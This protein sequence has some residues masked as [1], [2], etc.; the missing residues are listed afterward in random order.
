VLPRSREDD[1]VRV[2]ASDQRRARAVRGVLAATFGLNLAVAAAKV[3]YGTAVGSLAIRADGFHSAADAFNN[4]VLFVG[5]WLAARPPDREHPY[6]HKKVEVFAAMALG[7]GLLWVAFDVLR[8]AYA[9]LQGAPAPQVD[10]IAL[11]IL[12]GTLAVNVFVSRWERRAGQRLMSPA[13]ASDAAHT[14]SDVIVTLGVAVSAVLSWA[15]LAWADIVAGGGVAIVIGFV[16]VRVLKENA[17]YLVDTSLV[18]PRA[19]EKAARVEGVRE[20][21]GVKSHGSPGGIWIDLVIHVDPQLTVADAHAIAD[22][23]E[24]AVIAA[25]EGVS[26]VQVHVEPATTRDQ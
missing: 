25:F 19:V 7:L 13:L 9:R 4:V 1:D 16:G 5:A 15:G 2:R 14:A 8:D 22:R 20:V 21:R 24:D 17:N 10:L 12:L 11:P 6:G 26:G 3:L 18:D 23:A